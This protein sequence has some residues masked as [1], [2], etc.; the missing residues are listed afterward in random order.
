MGKTLQLQMPSPGAGISNTDGI[1]CF[2]EKNPEKS[3]VIVEKWQAYLKKQRL[4]LATAR[5]IKKKEQINT[6]MKFID[7][8]LKGKKQEVKEAKLQLIDCKLCS[9]A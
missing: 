6:L 3:Y 8:K 7:T 9:V 5:R 4:R 2:M 1:L